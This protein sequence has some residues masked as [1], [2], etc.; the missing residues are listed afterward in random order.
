[1]ISPLKDDTYSIFD[2]YALDALHDIGYAHTK[3]QIV[4]MRE[5]L[6]VSQ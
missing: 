1:M 3:D 2:T 4:I 5:Q 6:M